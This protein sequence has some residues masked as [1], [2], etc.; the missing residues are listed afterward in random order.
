MDIYIY[1]RHIHTQYEVNNNLNSNYIIMYYV[2]NPKFAPEQCIKLVIN[3]RPKWNWIR[4]YVINAEIKI[5][6]DGEIIGGRKT[7]AKYM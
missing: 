6:L 1:T 4:E 2:F 7:T 3:R 5:W